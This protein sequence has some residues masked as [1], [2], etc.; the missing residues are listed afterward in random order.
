MKTDRV[1]IP[2]RLA[3]RRA[4]EAAKLTVSHLAE[5]SGLQERTVARAES[6]TPISVRSLE[7]IAAALNAPL[8]NFTTG[9]QQPRCF[10]VAFRELAPSYVE[11]YSHFLRER[12]FSVVIPWE[13][14]FQ[15]GTSF[16]ESVV[17]EIARTDLVIVLMGREPD[18]TSPNASVELGQA[19]ANVP[20]ELGIA[21]GRGAPV[22]LVSEPDVLIPSD[23]A[24]ILCVR[25]SPNDL[26]S[27]GFAI[28][29][30]LAAAP[31]GMRTRSHQPTAVPPK[32]TPLGTAAVALKVE[33]QRMGGKASEV[34]LLQ[35]VRRILEL[36]DVENIA[37]RPG[38]N[39]DLGV[40]FAVWS[41]DLVPI[42]G[43]PLLIE[44]K[45]RISSPRSIES[46]KH[47]VL[48]SPGSWLLALY[49]YAD[50]AVLERARSSISNFIAVSINN[51]LH[52]L[53]EN[54]LTDV[55]RR[56][57]NQRVHGLGF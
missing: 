35:V 37:E 7:R 6:G 14:K 20:L 40:D 53:E 47:S 10:I 21:I 33:I 25:T 51:L 5:Q 16:I 15:P 31:V 49:L 17:D 36:S 39:R 23:L 50:N 45:Q 27:L 55:I 19:R 32:S 48:A 41:D 43:G 1:V 22:V 2:N 4:R 3:I 30:I 46:L 8:D 52:A 28:E 18:V 26:S 34:E 54:S 42:L 29:Q 24:G 9:G 38:P 56:L 11:R 13:M 12:G 57:R 44:L